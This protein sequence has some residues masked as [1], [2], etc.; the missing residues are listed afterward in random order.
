[1]AVPLR[2]YSHLRCAAACSAF[3]ESALLNSS[4]AEEQNEALHMHR[5]LPHNEIL[6]KPLLEMF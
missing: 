5:S 4:D 6:H 1:M 3:P 2:P